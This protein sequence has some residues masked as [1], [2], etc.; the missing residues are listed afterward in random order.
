MS[1]RARSSGSRI[2]WIASNGDAALRAAPAAATASRSGP[3]ADSIV[4][5][6]SVGSASVPPRARSRPIAIPSALW[7]ARQSRASTTASSG[8]ARHA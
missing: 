4:E 7:T 1:P 8:I 3:S 6:D 5:R 2:L